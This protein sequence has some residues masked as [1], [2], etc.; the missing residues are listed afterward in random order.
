MGMHRMDEMS[1]CGSFSRMDWMAI[2]TVG[3][4][5]TTVTRS[6]WT[7]STMSR[8]CGFGPPKIWVAPF[9]TAANGTHQALAWNIGT[10]CRMTSRSEMPKTSAIDDAI[11]CRKIA[12][13][14]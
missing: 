5:P 9:S 8:G 14:V 10:M 11:E 2:H 7:I 13:C 3:T 12:R 1:H 6:L 4:A